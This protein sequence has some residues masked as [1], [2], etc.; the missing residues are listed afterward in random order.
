[1]TTVT[2]G[3]NQ[4]LVGNR[5]MNKKPFTNAEFSR[6]LA[7]I[8]RLT[9]GSLAQMTDGMWNPEYCSADAA[10]YA[11]SVCEDLKHKIKHIENRMKQP[12]MGTEH[13]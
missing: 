12:T 9:A 2:A 13:E 7:S 6:L 8:N 4:E 3:I 1:M 10:F 11:A 5:V